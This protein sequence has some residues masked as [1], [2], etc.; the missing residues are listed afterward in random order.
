MGEAR[1]GFPG[2]VD[3]Y[4]VIIRAQN[5]PGDPD[6]LAGKLAPLL[7]L[8]PSTVTGMLSRGHL[9]VESSLS[10][11]EALSLHARLDAMGFPAAIVDPGGE[12]LSARRDTSPPD[13]ELDLDLELDFGVELDLEQ[14]DADVM[15]A[16]LD[17][18]DAALESLDLPDSGVD[19]LD[20]SAPPARANL[21]P[22]PV[23]HAQQDTPGAGWGML[24][25]D[26]AQR[27]AIDPAPSS[28][29]APSFG[30]EAP[31]PERSSQPEPSADVPLRVSADMFGEPVDEPPQPT[32][33]P[34]AFTPSFGAE[35]VAIAPLDS[36]RTLDA[37]SVAV[38]ASGAPVQQLA[39]TGL[40][41]PG[42]FDGER[43]MSAFDEDEDAPP[44]KPE[45]FDGRPPHSPFL[46]SALS[47][48]APGA[49]QIYNGEDNHAWYFAQRFWMIKPWIDAVRDAKQTAA[50]V[51]TYYAPSP[52]EG[53]IARA[54][55]FAGGWV[56]VV[57]F[58]VS[59]VSTVTLGVLRST[60]PEPIQR[61]A[62][63]DVLSA[64]NFAKMRTL[65]A[66][67]ESLSAL[68]DAVDEYAAQRSE[69][70]SSERTDRLF[71]RGVDECR[72]GRYQICIELMKRVRDADASHK[73][74]VEFITWAALAKSGAKRDMPKID[75]P[76]SLEAYEALLLEA[77]QL[78]RE[79][80]LPEPD[81]LEPDSPAS[82]DSVAD[83]PPDDSAP[84]VERRADRSPPDS[85][86]SDAPDD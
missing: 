17:V 83:P 78:D 57:V 76:Q 47:L 19:V 29:P 62:T 49:G 40:R 61:S 23:E 24:F 65:E 59:S 67:I 52:P 5:W 53:N 7:G 50:K 42:A 64:M 46:A 68:Q 35:P 74:A 18:S 10:H 66:R 77:E 1:L 41:R 3:V 16:D 56:A 30:A 25:P 8:N 13:V 36:P 33:P 34:V 84:D 71:Y 37:Q 31:E 15:I 58:I 69:F 26:L 73:T 85:D 4:S 80:E 20:F 28:E 48:I 21:A 39:S 54:L 55:K 45:G 6:G 82:D 72:S 22:E 27:A 14:L 11:D 12:L 9:T 51:R 43:L 60:R 44:Y 81:E 63:A 2:R 79:L 86:D 32:P 38:S 70:S 75:G